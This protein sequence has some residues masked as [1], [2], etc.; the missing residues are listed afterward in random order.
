MR[1]R[2]QPARLPTQLP[3]AVHGELPYGLTLREL[4]LVR[5]LDR[6]TSHAEIAAAF[7]IKPDT[8]KKH[9]A[10]IL[11]KTGMDDM[12]SLLLFAIRKRLLTIP[13]EARPDSAPESGGR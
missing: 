5:L 4:E 13:V 3:K 6:C 11:R 7:G 9:V 8:A 1:T 2:A 12:T 10:A